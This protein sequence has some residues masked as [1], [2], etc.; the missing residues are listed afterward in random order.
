MIIESILNE[1]CSRATNMK[2]SP[3]DCTVLE[4][5]QS[6]KYLQQQN[7]LRAEPDPNKQELLKSMMPVLMISGRYKDTKKAEGFVSHSKLITIDIDAKDNLH[8]YNFSLLKTEFCKIPNVAYCGLSVRGKGYFLIIPIAYPDKHELHFK[9]LQMYFATKGLTI[10]PSC[11]NINRLRYY[12]FDADAYF[13]HS[14][15]PLQAY[16]MPP[17]A[18]AKQPYNKTFEGQDKPVWEQYNEGL[19]FIEV[20]T[21]NGWQIESEAGAKIYF[22]RPGKTAGISAEFDSNKNIFYVF[23]SNG[24]PFDGNKGYNPFQVFAILEHNGNFSEAAKA[25]KPLQQ[26]NVSAKLYKVQQ[27]VIHSLPVNP[28][29]LIQ[30]PIITARLPP[31]EAPPPIRE[32][33]PE[34]PANDHYTLQQLQQIALK[35]ADR[36]R[37]PLPIYL[38]AWA[39]SMAPT[40]QQS[41]ITQTQFL[42]SLNY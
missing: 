18:K 23:S 8:I 39:Q 25:L 40:L 17:I 35:Q 22:I 15:K 13:N 4:E 10:D 28:L 31:M 9:W 38:K 27:P 20:L 12:S 14:A 41:G 16:Y 37:T 29:P 24:Q 30:L 26:K 36:I 34:P 1:P 32:P 33:Q 2:G 7:E 3:I 19:D 6:Q 21:N 11:K 5:L 42:N